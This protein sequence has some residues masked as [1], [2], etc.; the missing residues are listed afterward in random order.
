[1]FE[2]L[3]LYKSHIKSEWHK[4]NLKTRLQEKAPVS[5][6]EYKDMQFAEHYI[7]QQKKK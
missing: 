3:S 7:S 4:H 6:E 2:N 1:M 5:L